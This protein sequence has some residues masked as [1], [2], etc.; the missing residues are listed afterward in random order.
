MENEKYLLARN[1]ELSIREGFTA[2]GLGFFGG[3]IG[4]MK[5][6]ETIV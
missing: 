5:K 2:L 3:Y 6:M 1:L 4:I